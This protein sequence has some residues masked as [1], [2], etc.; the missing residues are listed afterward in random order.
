MRIRNIIILCGFLLSFCSKEK[1]FIPI[2]NVD[3]A[4][5]SFTAK[6][7]SKTLTLKSNYTKSIK[8]NKDN[9]EIN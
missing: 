1:P 2:F 6:E 8:I 3:I 7:G 9:Y 4:A 5:N